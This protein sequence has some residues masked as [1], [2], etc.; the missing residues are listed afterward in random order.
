MKYLVAL[1]AFLLCCP[2][3]VSLFAQEVDRADSPELRNRVKELEERVAELESQL[4]RCLTRL[5]SL[6]SPKGNPGLEG[7]SAKVTK[8]S[9]I[10]PVS[11]LEK[12]G[13]NFEKITPDMTDDEVFKTL[14]LSEFQKQLEANSGIM[15]D[16]GGGNWRNFIVNQK[17]YSLAFRD[18]FGNVK[19]MIKL[20]DESGWRTRETKAKPIE[21]SGTVIEISK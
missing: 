6:E 9:P 21:V 2:P 19:C 11:I 1:I 4:N 16:G 7:G 3:Q 14:G 17:G 5:A 15:M 20:P 10:I 13:T 8:S 12:L 18:F